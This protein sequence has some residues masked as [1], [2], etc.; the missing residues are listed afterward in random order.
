MNMRNNVRQEMFM[1]R[2][3]IIHNRI[4]YL[5]LSTPNWHGDCI[6]IPENAN[7]AYKTKRG[8]A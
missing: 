8:L 5:S 7:T 4:N 2:P 6:E 1:N 3:N